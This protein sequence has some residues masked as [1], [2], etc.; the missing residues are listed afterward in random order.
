VLVDPQALS[1]F[2]QPCSIEYEVRSSGVLAARIV[3]A[4]PEIN[5]ATAVQMVTIVRDDMLIGFSFR[6]K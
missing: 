3:S 6:M 5:A 4:H 2:A 1:S